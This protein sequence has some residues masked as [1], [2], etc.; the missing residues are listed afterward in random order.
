MPAMKTARS[1]FVVLGVLVFSGCAT[2]FG[3]DIRAPGVLSRRF[4]EH[5]HP[6]SQ[7][8]GVYLDPALH[9]MISTNKGGRFADPQT[10]H[11]GD[12][13]LPMA[14]E[15]FQQGFTEFVLIESEPTQEMLRQYAIPYLVY[16]KPGAFGNDVTLKGQAISF[17]TE[18][19][20]FDQDLGFLDRFRTTGSSDSKKVFAKKGGPQVNLNAALENNIESVVLHIQDAARSGR[21]KIGGQT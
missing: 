4:Y 7:R 17:E 16:I 18:A 14:I 20:V 9:G 6:E 3:W 10:Y 13:Y 11:I 15:A 5:V 21:W 12:A 19:F 8:V 2:L 1:L